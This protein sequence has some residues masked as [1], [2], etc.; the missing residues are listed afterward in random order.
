MEVSSSLTTEFFASV[1]QWSL[2]ISD[3]F[4]HSVVYGHWVTKIIWKN[5]GT[6]SNNGRAEEAERSKPRRGKDEATRPTTWP[7]WPKHVTKLKGGEAQKNTNSQ[8]LDSQIIEIWS[9][10]VQTSNTGFSDSWEPTKK[11]CVSTARD[12]DDKKEFIKAFLFF[13]CLGQGARGK[14]VRGWGIRG[15]R[16]HLGFRV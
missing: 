14:R 9:S 6:I 16:R 4:C 12:L 15:Q 8:S 13:S 2:K 7:D 10:L 5:Q 3:N 1:V 11:K